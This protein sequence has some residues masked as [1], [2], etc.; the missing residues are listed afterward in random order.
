M[1]IQKKWTACLWLLLVSLGPVYSQTAVPPDSRIMSET[2]VA[3]STD[4]ASQG[5]G[6]RQEFNDHIYRA[7]WIAGV[8]IFVLLLAILLYKKLAGKATMY[9]RGNIRVIARHNLGP[10]QS[11]MVAHIEGRKL[12]LGV[13]EQHINLINDLG[14]VPESEA[15]NNQNMQSN[16]LPFSDW[17]HRFMNRPE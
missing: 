13:T 4:K 12:V 16:T 15:Q 8:F 11:I 3:D 6:P 10:K 5:E 7:V 9:N 14:E 17:V 2:R 1:I